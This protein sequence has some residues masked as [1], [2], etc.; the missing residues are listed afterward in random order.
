MPGSLR[1]F[2]SNAGTHD[3]TDLPEFDQSTVNEIVAALE[4]LDAAVG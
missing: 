3:G 4:Q 1:G 2:I